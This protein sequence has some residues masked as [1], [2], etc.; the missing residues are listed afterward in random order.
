MPDILTRFSPNF[1]F[2]TDFN[3]G[4]EYQ[5]SLKPVQWE[6]TDTGT[7]MT[8]AKRTIFATMKTHLKRALCPLGQIQDDQKFSVHLIITIQSSG[9][10]TF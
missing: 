3:T 7:D 6:R 10:E 9:A 5:I 8:E 4:L 1:D 2:S